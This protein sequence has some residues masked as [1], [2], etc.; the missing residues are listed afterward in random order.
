MNTNEFNEKPQTPENDNSH[1]SE[2]EKQG[3]DENLTDSPSSPVEGSE[4]S[5]SDEAQSPATDQVKDS[6]DKEVKKETS[7]EEVSQETKSV[8]GNESSVDADKEEKQEKQEETTD[9]K[10]EQ[11]AGSFSEQDELLPPA[12]SPYEDE[13]E[14]DY[15]DYGALSKDQLTSELERLLNEFEI[16]KIRK[17]VE[18]IKSQF[19]KKHQRDLAKQKEEFVAEGGTE[20]DFQ[21]APD[22]VNDNFNNLMQLYKDKRA[23]YLDKIEKDKE[24]NL[25]ARFEVIESIKNL[26]NKEESLN[27]TFQEFR[28]LQD[29][30]REIGKVPQSEVKGIWEKYHFAVEQFYD[31]VKINKELR[32]LDL[33]KNLDA[34]VELCEKAEQLLLEDSVVKAFKILQE[35]HQQW[36][37]IG[38]VP[39]EKKEEIWER[40]KEA[41][42]KINKHHQE[43]FEGLKKDQQKNLKSKEALCKKVEEIN[44]LNLVKPKKWEEKSKEIIE[45]QKLWKTIGFAP[46]KYNNEIYQRFKTACDKFFDAKRAY[47]AQKHAEEQENL[48]KKTELC[49]QAEAMKD[50]TDWKKTT[51][52]F[53]QLQKIWKQTGPVPRKNSEA[54]WKRFRAACDHFFEAKKDFFS[55]IDKRQDD[56]LDAKNQLIEKVKQFELSGDDEADL[57]TLSDFQKEWSEIGFVPFDKKDEVQKEF[58]QAINKHFDSM[59]IEDEKRNLMN[60][61][62]K[63]EN[64]LDNARLK[65]KITPERNKIIN[66]IKDLENEITLYENNIGFFNDSKSSNALVD[67]IQEKIERAK[68]RISLLRK[69]LD[70]LD[71]LD[72]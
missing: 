47:F 20:K 22:T 65:K 62:N 17:R 46:K 64:W 1:A 10:E 44:K 60:F 48:E 14:G 35:Y 29:R 51:G 53:I 31:Y 42:V 49:L 4:K 15:S 34:K 69:K 41:T 25:A 36:R 71:E 27:K 6:E 72:D 9:T 39:R 56:N 58:R 68:K 43:F 30:W 59:K 61:R 32:D 7:E 57:K 33:R 26:I 8:S 19:Y 5:S 2:P 37:E 11:V 70:I 16:Q 38:P 21:P 45:I 28:A 52:E 12:Q 18:A 55:N 50:S 23:A 54:L 63:I 40:F 66:K 24:D 3:S 13:D 67:E